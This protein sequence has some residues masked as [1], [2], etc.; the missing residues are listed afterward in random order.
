MLLSPVHRPPDVR[1]F[2]TASVPLCCV[3]C[4]E[5]I[6]SVGGHHAERGEGRDYTSNHSEDQ[7]V[8][9]PIPVPSRTDYLIH[10]KQSERVLSPPAVLTHTHTIPTHT[11]TESYCCSNFIQNDIY[12]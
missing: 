1:A 11:H 12:I 2:Q 7:S 9:H 8:L 10:H 4:P 3:L 5:V 6:Q